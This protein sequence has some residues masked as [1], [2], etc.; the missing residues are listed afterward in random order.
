[1]SADSSLKICARYPRRVQF[2]VAVLLTEGKI[3]NE[4]LGCT[5]ASSA[6]ISRVSRM[7]SGGTGVL[8]SMTEQIAKED[9][10]K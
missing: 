9:E 7:L 6:T 8:R 5:G 4:I 1:M 2:D 3:Y 10:D